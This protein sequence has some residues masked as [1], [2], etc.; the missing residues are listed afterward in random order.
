LEATKVKQCEAEKFQSLMT[1]AQKRAAAEGDLKPVT[2]AR[3]AITAAA[4][5][6]DG[7]MCWFSDGSVL[8]INDGAI[9]AR[10]TKKAAKKGAQK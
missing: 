8:D 7:A 1:K 3:A 2:D 10:A 9:L 4:V 6:R 5:R